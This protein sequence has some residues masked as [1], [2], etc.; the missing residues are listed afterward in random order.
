MVFGG[1]GHK[2]LHRFA[3]KIV[4]IGQRF[5]FP[6]VGPGKIPALPAPEQIQK[7]RVVVLCGR[8]HDKFVIKVIASFLPAVAEG[9]GGFV[10]ASF[11]ST[12]LGRCIFLFSIPESF[13]TGI[14]ETN[15]QIPAA[16]LDV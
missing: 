11:V 7:T 8:V 1:Q 10:I 6:L 13:D 14:F 12:S 2:T 16:V 9:E 15:F 3:T 5:Q 4:G